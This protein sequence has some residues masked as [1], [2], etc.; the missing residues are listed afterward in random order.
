MPVLLPG[1]GFVTIGVSFQLSKS[2]PKVRVAAG[3]PDGV[4]F[5]GGGGAKFW[6]GGI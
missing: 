5:L 6:G 4:V 2:L 1:L 3:V